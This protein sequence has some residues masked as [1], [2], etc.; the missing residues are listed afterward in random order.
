MYKRNDIVVRLGGLMAA[1]GGNFEGDMPVNRVVEFVGLILALAKEA[2][3]KL[4]YVS[5]AHTMAWATPAS[6]PRVGGAVRNRFPELRLS[7]H[8]HDT[9][10][11]GIANA[12]AG[13]QMGVGIF[14]AAV[15]GPG[16][17]PFAGHRGAAGNICT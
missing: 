11:M 5:L 13:M 10:G 12:W 9:R 6:I 7:L 4:E 3:V 2:E 1:F 17:C 15:A 16:G 8:L 14:D